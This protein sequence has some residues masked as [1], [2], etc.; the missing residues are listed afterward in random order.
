MSG[1]V[2]SRKYSL[3]FKTAIIGFV[4]ATG[5]AMGVFVITLLS[6]LK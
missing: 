3:N 2:G 1:E 4:V 6:N 5:I